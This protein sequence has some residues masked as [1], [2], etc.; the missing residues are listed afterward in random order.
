MRNHTANARGSAATAVPPRATGEPR[1]TLTAT[2]TITHQSCSE[3]T[4]A[5]GPGAKGAGSLLREDV[6]GGP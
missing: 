4:G 6:S 3:E 2:V 1:A 5:G